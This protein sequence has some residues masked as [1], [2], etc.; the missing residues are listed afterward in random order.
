[1]DPEDKK[2]LLVHFCYRLSNA[3][4]TLLVQTDITPICLKI[5]LEAEWVRESKQTQIWNKN[6]TFQGL[7]HTIWSQFKLRIK[8]NMPCRI[9]STW[10]NMKKCNL[11]PVF[12]DCFY[13]QKQY[14]DPTL[15]FRNEYCISYSANENQTELGKYSNSKFKNIVTRTFGKEQ[16]RGLEDKT[17]LKF[18]SFKYRRFSEFG[19][20]FWYRFPFTLKAD[21]SPSN[22]YKWYTVCSARNW[23]LVLLSSSPKLAQ[24]HRTSKKY[25]DTWN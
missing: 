21:N 1:M 22:N 20:D 8:A 16:R 24:N 9:L 12:R 14:H 15:F 13:Q 11:S 4:N 10:I 17:K 18:P 5:I 23:L 3:P 25:H 19:G 2:L 6:R 7:D